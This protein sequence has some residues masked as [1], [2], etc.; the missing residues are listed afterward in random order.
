MRRSSASQQHLPVSW[1][2]PIPTVILRCIEAVAPGFVTS[3]YLAAVT[4][5]QEAE[6]RTVVY[7]LRERGFRINTHCGGYSITENGR[8]AEGSSLRAALSSSQGKAGFHGQTMGDEA[9]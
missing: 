9:P 2:K 8:D 5:L 4:G 6:V 1:R 7:R 3:R